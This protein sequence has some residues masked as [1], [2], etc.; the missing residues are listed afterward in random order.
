MGPS[1][2]VLEAWEC[3]HPPTARVWNARD[4]WER[5]SMRGPTLLGTR[6]SRQHFED[7]IYNNISIYAVSSEGLSATLNPILLN[8]LWCRALAISIPSFL[9]RA[10]L[11]FTITNS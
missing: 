8:D 3:K 4:L 5:T 1:I 2:L 7:P 10:E 11:T 9:V 6:L